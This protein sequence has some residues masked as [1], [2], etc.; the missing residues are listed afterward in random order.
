MSLSTQIHGHEPVSSGSFYTP[1]TFMLTAFILSQDYH[2]YDHDYP[3]RWTQEEMDVSHDTKPSCHRCTDYL[4]PFQHHSDHW[5]YHHGLLDAGDAEDMH[6]HI[7]EHIHADKREEEVQSTAVMTKRGLLGDV[8]DA[9]R[10]LLAP[11][12]IIPGFV[13]IEK[14]SLDFAVP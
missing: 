8:G 2:H 3:D 7:H 9:V 1:S 6:A 11:L 13:S 4:A 5:A 10:P 14:V 12:E